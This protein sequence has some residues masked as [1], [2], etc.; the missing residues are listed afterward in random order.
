M[1]PAPLQVIFSDPDPFP[2]EWIPVMEFHTSVS[3]SSNFSAFQH[4]KIPFDMF[5]KAYEIHEKFISTLESEKHQILAKTNK[6]TSTPQLRSRK[7]VRVIP[8]ERTKC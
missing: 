5:Y 2:S 3:I 4:S 6:M 1:V 7:Q 8:K